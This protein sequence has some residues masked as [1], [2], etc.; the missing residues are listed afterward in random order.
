LPNKRHCEA[1]ESDQFPNPATSSAATQFDLRLAFI[2]LT[3]I[4]QFVK[5]CLKNRSLDKGIGKK[6]V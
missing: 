6:I 2:M 4:A 1:T 5:K 3:N